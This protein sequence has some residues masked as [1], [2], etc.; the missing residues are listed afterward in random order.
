[1]CAP[2][3]IEEENLLAPAAVPVETQETTEHTE[4][5][6]ADREWARALAC[7]DRI[8]VRLVVAKE[9]VCFTYVARTEA[10]GNPGIPALATARIAFEQLRTVGEAAQAA[11]ETL[12]RKEGAGND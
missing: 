7:P 3:K 5:T 6:E 2:H 8:E 1:M 12:L 10:H 9:G 4:D 11:A